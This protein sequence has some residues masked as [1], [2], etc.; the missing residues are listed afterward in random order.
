MATPVNIRAHMITLNTDLMNDILDDGTMTESKCRTLRQ[1]LTHIRND[2]YQIEHD[3]Q[4]IEDHSDRSG[5]ALQ[6][7]TNVI[8][9]PLQR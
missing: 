1:L 4:P 8:R 6:V 7:T 9:F 5:A 3:T 2:A